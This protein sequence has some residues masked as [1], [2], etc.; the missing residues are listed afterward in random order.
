MRPDDII[1]CIRALAEAETDDFA[2]LVKISGLDPA[3]DFINGDLTGI[4]LRDVNLTGYNLQACR[5]SR[6]AL[7]SGFPVSS[8]VSVNVPFEDDRKAARRREEDEKED[9]FRRAI[10]ADPKNVAI[11]RN[12][13]N[14]MTNIRHDHDAA[15]DLY[16]RALA[17][18]P[19][20]AN[21]L[22]NFAGMLL[23]LGRRGEGMGWLAKVLDLEPTDSPLLAELWFYVL[24]HDPARRG[25]ALARLKKLVA[26]GARSPGWDLARHCQRARQDGFSDSLADPALLEALAAVITEGAS[27]QTLEAFPSW[28]EI[29]ADPKPS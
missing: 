17:A 28:R 9:A 2:S 13:A 5:V 14:F 12:F 24:A 18:D 15:E 23:A 26:A 3:T 1:E 27:P 11:L 19:E 29:G 22:G 10:A 7:P 6:G 4:D 16:K 21:T 25:E 8:V 20:N